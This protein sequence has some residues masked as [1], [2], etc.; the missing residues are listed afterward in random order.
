[1][2]TIESEC[3]YVML[4]VFDS[5]IRLAHYLLLHKTKCTIRILSEC[6]GVC[7]CVCVCVCVSE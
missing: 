3:I 6:V 2:L 4:R 1:M 5:I 7:V